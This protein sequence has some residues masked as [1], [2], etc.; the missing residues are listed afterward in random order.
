MLACGWLVAQ[1]TRLPGTRHCLVGGSA[2][3]VALSA[4]SIADADIA[5][6]EIAK[7]NANFFI[8]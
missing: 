3:L 4:F 5:S 8:F 2:L 6:V 1:R 7:D